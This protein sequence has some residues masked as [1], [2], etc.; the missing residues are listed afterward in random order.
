MAPARSCGP[1]CSWRRA[2]TKAP[3]GTCERRCSST[4]GTA[5]EQRDRRGRRTDRAGAG[6]AGPAAARPLEELNAAAADEVIVLEAAGTLRPRHHQRRT[7]PASERVHARPGLRPPWAGL[8]TL[9]GDKSPALSPAGVPR[10][11][12]GLRHRHRPAPVPVCASVARRLLRRCG[13]RCSACPSEAPVALAVRPAGA[14]SAPLADAM[15]PRRRRR[16]RHR[17]PPGD[18]RRGHHPR[19]PGAGGGR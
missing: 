17:R 13:P 15:A 9:R 5:N 14:L 10:P 18:P 19:R 3:N 6:R 7:G 1:I 12:S 2:T 4:P 8:V 11:G 16:R